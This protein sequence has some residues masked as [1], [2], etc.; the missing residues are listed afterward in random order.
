MNHIITLTVSVI[1]IF[2]LAPTAWAHPFIDQTEPPRLSSAPV[3]TQNVIVWYSE[4]IEIDYSSLKVFDSAGERVDDA[5]TSYYEGDASLSI[6]TLPLEEGVY[7]VS[8][9]TLS[10]VDGHLVSDAFVFAVGDATIDADI[11]KSVAPSAQVFITEAVAKFPGLLGQ[12]LVLGASV[13]LLLTWGTRRILCTSDDAKHIHHSRFM[14]LI[15][16]GSII[17]LGSNIFMLAA[18]ASLLGTQI[19]DALNTTFGNTVLIRIAITIMLIVAWFLVDRRRSVTPIWGIAFAILGLGLAAT[20]TMIGHGAASEQFPA[21]ALDYA[22][23]IIAGVWIGGVAYLLVVMLP[24]ISKIGKKA[25]SATLVI[26]P[27][28]SAIFVTCVGIAAV[29]GPLLLWLLED[30]VTLIIDSTYGSI[31]AA[32]LVFGTGMVLA[33]AYNWRLASKNTGKSVM[34]RFRRSLRIELCLG[35]ALLASVAM[36][37]NTTLPSGEAQATSNR[38]TPTGLD[39][40]LFS[41]D[42]TFDLNVWPLTAGSNTLT[43]SVMDTKGSELYD[44]EGTSVTVTSVDKNIAPIKVDLDRVD[45]NTY[46]GQIT[47]GFWGRWDLSIEAMRSENANESA[48]VRTLVK[49]RLAD[50]SVEILEYD[51]PSSASPLHIVHDNAN[52]LWL[53]DPATPRLWSFDTETIEFTEHVYDGRGSVILDIDET[54]LVWF[55]DI[56][57]EIIGSFNPHSDSFV[58]IPI[59]ESLWES[60][61]AP[62]PVWLY[63]ASDNSIWVSVPNKNSVLEY[64]SESGQ[65]TVHVSPT[66]E[67]APL[68][69]FEDRY[70]NIWFTE[71]SGGGIAKLD[72]T[73]GNI[74][75]IIPDP[76]LQS[77]ETISFDLDGNAWISEHREGGG[78]ARIDLDSKT[79]ERINAPNP[80]ALAN[81]VSFDRHQNVWFALHTIDSL[82]VYEPNTGE[83]AEVAIP[84]QSSWVQF[85]TSDPDGNIWFAEQRA[86]KLGNVRISDPGFVSY[87][88]SPQLETFSYA[89]I[90]AP[91]MGAVI[92]IASLLIVRAFTKR[93]E[94]LAEFNN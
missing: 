32:K 8:S 78:I 39:T 26:I 69:I 30:S 45:D 80:K 5:D 17:V 38:A 90:V 36:L 3:G 75:E 27:T 12:T 4:S 55:T 19:L 41:A 22:H 83:L 60:E 89:Q 28:F 2:M 92:V 74:E 42:A 13:A 82:V 86:S 71:Q 93:R 49:P 57:S 16:V 81:S 18:H 46:S 29:T 48:N 20:F 54:G 64:D 40:M 76:P 37:T 43:V 65:F 34:R 51:L 62:L 79:I 33:G 31:L 6:T 68:A 73:T 72:R 35:V 10:K 21:I 25:D 47:L 94:L 24:Y 23:N 87:S 44:L 67:S 14:M 61:G 91:L 7:T 66:L 85:T 77:S 56:Q 53:S 84:T 1:V 88:A 50:L 63:A 70:G 58:L 11:A 59:P 52:T 15:G 9:R